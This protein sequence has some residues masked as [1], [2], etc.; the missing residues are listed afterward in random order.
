M[1]SI[2]LQFIPL[3][4]GAFAPLMIAAII[5][6]LSSKG[7]L[8]KSVAFVLGR[9]VGY[10]ILGI[11]F[12]GITGAIA[13]KGGGE[14]DASLISLVIITT[15]GILLLALA[16]RTFVGEDDPDAP[17][18]K[19]LTALDKLGP[20]ASFGIGFVY[21]VIG[22]R[23]VVL[24]LAGTAMI[25]A[26]E[27]STAEIAIALFFLVLAVTW[28]L[29]LPIAVY[30]VLGE[31]ADTTLGKMNDW[32]TRSNRIVTTVILG[33]FGIVLLWDGLSGILL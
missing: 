2:I 10:V 26:A 1:L 27:F 7:G 21:T 32:L 20:A 33:L 16:L 18:P 5:L 28:P 11:V 14:D 9:F 31:R 30:V 12:I 4:L 15:L 22:I 25:V 13:A 24:M 8:R 6:M 19:L 23:F 29:V 3:A 17:P